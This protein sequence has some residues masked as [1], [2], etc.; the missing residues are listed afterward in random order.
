MSHRVEIHVTVDGT[1]V[2]L[3][4]QIRKMM[5]TL[6]EH[7]E[8]I[9]QQEAGC[10]MLDYNANEIVMSLLRQLYRAKARGQELT[11]G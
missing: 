11:V 2:P 3:R 4:L 10:V 6:V 1:P 7:R 9:Y 5:W 8:N